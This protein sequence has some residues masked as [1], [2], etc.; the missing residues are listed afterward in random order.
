MATL[1]KA[2]LCR[3]VAGWAHSSLGVSRTCKV[4]LKHKG[5]HVFLSEVPHFIHDARQKKKSSINSLQLILLVGLSQEE[6]QRVGVWELGLWRTVSPI[7]TS[8]MRTGQIHLSSLDLDL[9]R[10]KG[11]DLLNK[12]QVPLYS[13]LLSSYL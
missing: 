11:Q 9:H 4:H 6:G 2:A 8:L 13:N 3:A 1:V 12:P 7:V 5:L 10:P